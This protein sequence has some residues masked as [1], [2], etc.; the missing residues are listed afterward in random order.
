MAS[1]DIKHHVYLITPHHT[2]RCANPWTSLSLSIYIYICPWT[3]PNPSLISLTVSV[4]VKHHVYLLTYNPQ[5][6]AVC[7]IPPFRR[8]CR[9]LRLKSLEEDAGKRGFE[10]AGGCGRESDAW[11]V[12]RRVP[13]SEA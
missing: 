8:R 2:P 5:A 9:E 7:D 11:A 6:S 13:E 4:D 10:F 3:I 12:W 1:V